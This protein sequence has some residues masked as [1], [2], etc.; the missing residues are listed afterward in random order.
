[1]SGLNVA[2]SVLAGRKFDVI[3]L[4]LAGRQDITNK[5]NEQKWLGNVTKNISLLPDNVGKY[6]AYE[7]GVIY[8]SPNTGAHEIH[9]G[10]LEKFK[11]FG[12]ERFFGYPQTDELTAPDKI[13]KFNHFQKGSIY[14]SPSTGAHEVHGAIKER[15]AAIGWEKSIGYP[16]TD[17]TSTP[18]G[19]GRYNHFERGSVYWSPVTGAHEIY[20]A[21]R[22]KWSSMGWEKSQLGYPTSGE[23]WNNDKTRRFNVFQ[24]GTIYW[25]ASNQSIEVVFDG[26]KELGPWNASITFKSGVAAGGWSNLVIRADG[27]YEFSGHLHDSGA[28]SYD[29]S[30]LWSILSKSNQLFTF[31]HEG[32]I[33]GTFDPGS[34]DLDW[35]VKKQDDRIRDNWG[36]LVQGTTVNWHSTVDTGLSQFINYIKTIYSVATAVIAIV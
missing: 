30:V 29:V 22:D 35:D 2:P 5:L 15:W 3:S 1:M 33:H 28:L 4:A 23:Q 12:S 10:I 25:T 32:T 9:G 36:D 18:D 19:I 27:S 6:E 11:S 14:W 20:G 13:G 24:K 21:I 34:R 8:W 16:V 26:P 31:G 17:E 7:N